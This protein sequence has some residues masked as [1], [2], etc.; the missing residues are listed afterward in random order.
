MLQIGGGSPKFFGHST[1][2]MAYAQ[3]DS[4]LTVGMTQAETASAL[5]VIGDDMAAW[6]E[7]KGLST[8]DGA[9]FWV[10]PSEGPSQTNPAGARGNPIDWWAKKH[11]TGHI[12][13]AQ[14][15]VASDSTFDA[16]V[17]CQG[18]TVNGGSCASMQPALLQ[19]LPA[20]HC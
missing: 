1:G 14:L 18:H 3:Y 8:S 9:V 12:V 15:T 11:G 7:S 6:S 4:W 17:N 16:Q 5:G 20:S 19:R 10:D 13:I 2:P